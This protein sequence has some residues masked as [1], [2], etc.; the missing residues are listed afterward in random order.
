MLIKNILIVS[1]LEDY[2][3]SIKRHYSFTK[4][5]GIATGFSKLVKTYYLTLGKTELYNDITFIN[6][7]EITD[8]FLEKID[9]ILFIREFNIMDI[10]DKVKSIE[11]LYLTNQ[12]RIKIG[13][14]SDSINWIFTKK[15]IIEFPIKYNNV[16]WYNF[17]ENFFDILCVQTE[18]MKRIDLEKIKKK[19]PSRYESIK[20]KVFISR[21]GV[22]HNNPLD[23]EIE[24]PY[25]IDHSYCRDNFTKLNEDKA[26]HPLC[27]TAINKKFSP[28]QGKNYNNKKHILIY[29][30]R[31]RTNGGKIAYVMKDIMNSLGE[32][33]ELHIFPGRFNIP[34]SNVKIYSSKY[35]CNLQLLRDTIF[36]SCKNVIIHFPFDDKSKDKYLKH[37]EIAIDFSSRRPLNILCPPGNAKLLEY[38]Y[39]GLKV[40]T[41]KNV[42][43]SHLVINGKNGITLENIANFEE[44]VNAI[45]NLVNFNYDK[46][47]TIQ[48]TIKS[49][50]WNYI[51]QEFLDYLLAI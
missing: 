7:K 45:K 21:M 4:G 41:E 2:H 6:D 35:P 13:M 8:T 3:K 28:E 49:N 12:K 27:Y 36:Y 19:L 46:K 44:Y 20:S 29:M 11:K 5:Y 40:V 48:K 22:F 30:G 14:K 42:N 34:N 50:G 18:E 24:N 33:Y 9:F 38:C 37:A 26:L 31:I 17:V 15:Y 43:N 10:F 51:A 16:K 23:K 32:D 39:Y 25:K 47:Y 1:E